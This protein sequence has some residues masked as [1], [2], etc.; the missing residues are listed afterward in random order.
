VQ[1]A[2]FSLIFC[3]IQ[4]YKLDS[5]YCLNQLQGETI[6]GHPAKKFEVT[7]REGNKTETYYQWVAT[8]LK[9]PVKPAKTDGSWGMEPKNVKKGASDNAFDLPSGVDKDKTLVPD[10]LH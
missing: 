4:C 8:D 9:I 10:A 1:V 7:A 3:S 6:D 5:I 2:P